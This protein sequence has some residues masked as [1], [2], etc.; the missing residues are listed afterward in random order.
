MADE[1]CLSAILNL[2]T[3]FISEDSL[4]QKGKMK[5]LNQHVVAK[6]CFEN[7]K[8]GLLNVSVFKIR[9]GRGK[10]QAAPGPHFL[11]WCTTPGTD[12]RLTFMEHPEAQGH[13]L[14]TW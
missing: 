13:Q 2:K 9:H 11:G 10:N 4:M 14:K 3:Q 8:L 5:H 7:S 1:Q 6:A 12:R